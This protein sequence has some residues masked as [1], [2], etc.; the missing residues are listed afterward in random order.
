VQLSAEQVAQ[1]ANEEGLD[2]R[3]ALAVY[4]QESSSGANPK[5]SSKGA[6]GG[7]QV[8]PAT[9]ASMLPGGNIDDPADN[10][11]AGIRYLKTNYDRYGGD[12]DKTIAAYF[13]GPGNVD[14]ANGIPLTND[15]TTSTPQYV[16]GVR[17]KLDKQGG[18]PLQS[19]TP[20][21]CRRG[22][23]SATCPTCKTCRRSSLSRRAISISSTWW[24]PRCPPTS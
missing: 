1:I 24:R 17:A 13:T 14:K 3:L 21:T 23:K 20:R 7:F 11:R 9:F 5:T 8:L 4:Q 6:R 16:A 15:G 2:P 10:A 19:G 18:G 22:T 12:V